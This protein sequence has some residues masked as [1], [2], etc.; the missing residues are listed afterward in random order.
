[1]RT[2]GQ[3]SIISVW[4][5]QDQPQIIERIGE[6]IVMGWEIAESCMDKEKD[7][8][9]VYSNDGVRDSDNDIARRHCDVPES[10]DPMKVNPNSQVLEENIELK[11]CDVKECTMENQIE[12]SKIHLVENCHKEEQDMLCVESSSPRDETVKSEDQKPSNHKK[13]SPPMKPLSRSDGAGNI[14]LNCTVPQ[15]FA[16][17]TE[18]RASCGTRPVGPE[19]AVSNGTNTSCN[20]NNLQ[21]TC[22]T[23]KPQ[24][25]SSLASRKPLQPDNKKHPDEEDSCSIASSTAASVK[26]LKFKMTVPAAPVFRST[27]RA[28]KRKEFYSKL[29]EKQ[30]A[31]EAEKTQCEARTKD[32]R[33]AA[34][35]QLRK[36]LM[37]KAN[38]M[39]S[40]Y[41][42][43]PP[44]K[45]ELK[46]LPT[47][48]AKSPK[49]GRRK[50]YS[51]AVNS[52][53]GDN[54]KGVS[55]RVNRR[56]LGSYK[57]DTK[58][59]NNISRSI[60]SISNDKDEPKQVRESTKSPPLGI[61][62]QRNV[63]IPIQS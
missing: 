34:L 33:D 53:Q 24:P 10:D 21:A 13:L 59:T 17:A 25:R 44:S 16:L 37:F 32:E 46:K 40:F 39:P 14:R 63:D 58:A 54:Q 61:T 8:V 27:D 26:T 4:S 2:N 57:E 12:I 28:E 62:G 31:L 47:T 23:K 60:N 22:K 20:T 42:E 30:Q 5:N 55:G 41:H 7:C 48:R 3:T 35:K 19:I 43:G 1:M 45:V 36:S 29:E 52:T 56:S 50:S 51:D 15:P 38:P 11:D 9:I 18:K 6:V 49:L